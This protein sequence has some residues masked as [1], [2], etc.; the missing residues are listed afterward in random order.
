MLSS[1]SSS[2]PTVAAY[3]DSIEQQQHEPSSS[4]IFRRRSI[5][6]PSYS[7]TTSICT[8][9]LGDSNSN[10]A[11]LEW[12]KSD[13]T[14]HLPE[15]DAL[16]CY[17]VNEMAEILRNR[18]L[19][20]DMQS[21]ASLAGGYVNG[22][23]GSITGGGGHITPD[24]LS[25]L[26]DFFYLQS[27]NGDINTEL[28]LQQP[29]ILENDPYLKYANFTID[30]LLKIKRLALMS[31]NRMTF[32][33]DSFYAPQHLQFPFSSQ[34]NFHHS[35]PELRQHENITI[36]LNAKHLSLMD[37]KS[38]EWTYLKQT[39]QNAAVIKHILS[40]RNSVCLPSSL[41]SSSSTTTTQ[42]IIQKEPQHGSSVNFSRISKLA[43]LRIYM[44]KLRDKVYCI[45][46]QTFQAPSPTKNTTTSNI[47]NSSR[48][49]VITEETIESYDIIENDM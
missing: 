36:P 23:R 16:S 9:G 46:Y 5:K 20:F 37:M 48:M 47:I 34:P 19:E 11:D 14:R 4:I 39:S 31:H 38:F 7:R 25:Q 21:Q 22:N 18:F 30:E 24:R 45:V 43:M 8:S 3:F 15:T 10:I 6:H 28:N 33:V 17:D 29:D 1:R 40:Q 13:F 26:N 27:R 41:S 32:D 42:T 49:P 12:D 2:T 44:E 35:M